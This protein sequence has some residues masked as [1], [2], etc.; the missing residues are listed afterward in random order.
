MLT[1]PNLIDVEVFRAGDYGERGVYTAADLD[2]IAADYNPREHEA[3]V[4][5][6]HAQSGPAHGWVLGLRALGDRLVATLGR[7]SPSLAE[8]IGAGAFRKR[9]VEIY[10]RFSATGRPYLKAVSFLGAAAPEVKG[11]ADPEFAETADSVASFEEEVG[12]AQS[13]KERLLSAG[14]WNPQWER[15]GLLAVFQA[16]DGTPQFD[17]LAGHLAAAPPVSFGEASRTETASFA[18]DPLSGASPESLAR[19]RA[20]LALVAAEPAL[21]YRDALLRAH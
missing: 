5:I 20:A 18:E 2:A 10:R 11:L 7:I 19:H 3:P 15:N 9:S 12:V 21:A 1:T 17:V 13:A 6:D 14:R 4:T 16:L 8:A